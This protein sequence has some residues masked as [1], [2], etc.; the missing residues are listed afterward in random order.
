MFYVYQ[1]NAASRDESWRRMDKCKM[2]HISN[3]FPFL[4]FL[5]YKSPPKSPSKMCPLLSVINGWSISTDPY[6]FLLQLWN[7]EMSK[8]QLLCW[9]MCYNCMLY[10]II[11]IC[12]NK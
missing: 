7:L 6:P 10:T 12:S 2:Y 11:I 9:T 4:L 1:P 5:I 8:L 3:T